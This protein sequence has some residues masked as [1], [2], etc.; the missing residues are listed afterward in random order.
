M[1]I[2]IHED[3]GSP[4]IAPMEETHVMR[5]IGPGQNA[6]AFPQVA[7]PSAP[8]AKQIGIT[9]NTISAFFIFIEASLVPIA[10]IEGTPA[11]VDADAMHHIIAKIA[12]IGRT[13]RPG[14]FTFAA[15]HT[16]LILPLIAA[17]VTVCA[18]KRAVWQIIFENALHSSAIGPCQH[19]G[20][21]LTAIAPPAIILNSTRIAHDTF[22]AEIIVLKATHIAGSI[23]PG[24]SALPVQ[25]AMLQRSFQ[26]PPIRI[27][28]FTIPMGQ[29]VLKFTFV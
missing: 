12:L 26:H 19:T 10:A 21:I 2:G 7:Q 18:G 28:P 27:L 5:T 29:I 25:V 6:N 3:A 20:A 4:G 22:A 16:T 17:A 14:E 8:V 9:H 1:S 13:V 11:V 15:F 24:T 23:P